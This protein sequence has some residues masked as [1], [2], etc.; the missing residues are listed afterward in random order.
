MHGSQSQ[1]ACRGFISEFV[2]EPIRGKVAFTA[3][4]EWTAGL[5]SAIWKLYYV[6]KFPFLI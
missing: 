1:G 4:L 3:H 6:F 5:A 2:S